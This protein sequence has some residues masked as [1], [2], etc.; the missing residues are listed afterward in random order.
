MHKCKKKKSEI[1]ILSLLI[2]IKKVNNSQN[3]V[4]CLSKY[5]PT[6]SHP[7][8]FNHSKVETNTMQ[9]NSWF[10]VVSSTTSSRVTILT[11]KFY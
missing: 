11:Y 9:Q 3:T 6:Q 1:F 10:T 5:S 2:H 7:D 8:E 4:D